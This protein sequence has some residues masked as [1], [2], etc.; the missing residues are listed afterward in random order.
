M[1]EDFAFGLMMLCFIDIFY[2]EED[3]TGTPEYHQYP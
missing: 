2:G 3:I 1:D